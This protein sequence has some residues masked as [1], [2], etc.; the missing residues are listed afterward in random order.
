M[1]LR[2]MC[3]LKNDLGSYKREF[4]AHCALPGSSTA[5]VLQ[6]DKSLGVFGCRGAESFE[7]FLSFAL[8]SMHEP[9]NVQLDT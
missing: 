8:Y 4:G 3:D 6:I 9:R 5:V 2:A 7:L 1:A